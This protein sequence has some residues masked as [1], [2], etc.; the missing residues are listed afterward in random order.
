MRNRKNINGIVPRGSVRF[1]RD[2]QG[3]IT[4]AFPYDR[5]LIAIIKTIDGYKWHLEER[6]WSFPGDSNILWELFSKFPKEHIIIGSSLDSVIWDQSYEGKVF[7]I[8]YIKKLAEERLRLKGYSRN[9]KESYLRHIENYIAFYHQDPRKLSSWHVNNYIVQL[10]DNSELSRSTHNQ[11]ASALGFLYRYVLKRDEIS[12]G[13]L[14]P[15]KEK[16]L[17]IVLSIEEINTI[18]SGIRNLKHR[19]IL[20]LIYSAG[21]RISEAIYLRPEDIDRD[22]NLIHIKG[23]KGKKDR[24]TILSKTATTA[25]DD[26]LRTYKP[27][28]RWLFPGRDGIHPMSKRAVQLSFSAVLEKTDIKKHATIHTLRHSFATHLLEAG[29]NLRYIQELLGHK[30]PETTQLY[31]H[32]TRRDLANITSP[33]DRLEIFK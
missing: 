26:Y 7:G 29:V 4:V 20:M 11:I 16:K 18:L 5:D 24:Y 9:T 21:L 27:T 6:C 30:R 8:E 33:L 32:V 2:Y 14:R 15:K 19:A 25:L 3:R 22:R 31:T 28:S 1:G 13:I 10:M 17:P 23:A 12:I